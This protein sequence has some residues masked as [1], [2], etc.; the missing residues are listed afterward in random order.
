[1]FELAMHDVHKNKMKINYVQKR[2]CWTWN[3]FEW[4]KNGVKSGQIAFAMKGLRHD[5]SMV[6][7]QQQQP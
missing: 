1:M 5:Y 4:N 7:I 3:L 6:T 2:S